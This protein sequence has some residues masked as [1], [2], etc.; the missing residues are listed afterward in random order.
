MIS[1]T[2]A[3]LLLALMIRYPNTIQRICTSCLML[4]ILRFQ[5]VQT[6]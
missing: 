3:Q 2:R 4:K 6:L 1:T 5:T